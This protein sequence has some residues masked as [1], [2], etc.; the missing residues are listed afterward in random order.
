VVAPEISVEVQPR[1]PIFE[2]CHHLREK[3]AVLTEIWHIRNRLSRT[4]VSRIL[5]RLQ[6]FNGHAG[7]AAACGN[8]AG[9][10]VL[11]EPLPSG[12]KA[13]H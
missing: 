4:V 3:G 1:E 8:D 11:L 6:Q 9:Q 5:K 10:A 2:K 13:R 7:Q 12:L